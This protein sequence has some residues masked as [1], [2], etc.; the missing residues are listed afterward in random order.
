[1][2]VAHESEGRAAGQR[3]CEGGKN[4]CRRKSPSQAS[5][6]RWN[7]SRRATKG[8]R[9]KGEHGVL[10]SPAPRSGGDLRQQ[11]AR[12]ER[13]RDRTHAGTR[14]FERRR[15]ARPEP[16][17]PR[18]RR[19]GSIALP[20]R[21]PGRRPPG[22][23]WSRQGRQQETRGRRATRPRRRR[24]STSHS[25]VA[26][27]PASSET[28]KAGA[29]PKSSAASPVRA[30]HLRGLTVSVETASSRAFASGARSLSPQRYPGAIGI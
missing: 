24:P 7:R 9:G 15:S 12:G 26:S 11:E 5:G 13:S 19:T 2:A 6:T 20:I 3:W 10:R 18:R 14:R 29:A 28:A 4:D 22:R 30:R 23:T 17:R 27:T 21:R 1:M 25:K 16:E 8:P